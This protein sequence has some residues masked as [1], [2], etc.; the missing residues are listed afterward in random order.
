MPLDPQ[1]EMLLQRVSAAG[2]P[3]YPSLSPEEARRVMEA[4]SALTA[5]EPPVVE[6]V[7]DMVVP[8]PSGGIPLR[9][10]TPIGHPPF[11]VLVYFHGGGFVLGSLDTHDSLCR[12]IA[13]HSG[14]A[15]VSV[16]YRLAPEHKFP[17][18]VEDALAATRWVATN[19]SIIRCDADR[20]AVGGDSAGGNLATV[21]AL[22]ARD[23][24]DPK[25]RFQ[26]LLYPVTDHTFSSPSYQENGAGYMLSRD[27][28]EWYRDHYLR[29]EADR[30]HP[31]ASPLL[32]E[33]LHGLP[34]ALVI[35]AEFDPL[36][37]EGEAYAAKMRQ[38]GVPVE[39]HRYN[40]MIH[41]FV[42]MYPSLDA[43]KRALEE[44]GAALQKALAL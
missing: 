4:R 17:A 12:A 29:T 34:P 5:G 21:V 24:G 11:P 33:D 30:S 13:A 25:L 7:S 15:V 6:A 16:G 10:Y 19:A 32:A 1:V 35:T 44:I 23:A 42:R 14:C 26:L 31:H 39:L 18:A 2:L 36:R 8:G 43:G 9:V 37:D 41:G 27:D 28:M 3:P 22:L 20:L 40:G 38:A